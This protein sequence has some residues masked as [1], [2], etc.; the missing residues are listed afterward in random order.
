MWPPKF[1]KEWSKSFPEARSKKSLNQCVGKLIRVVKKRL[2]KVRVNSSLFMEKRI[3]FMSLI[4]E[5]FEEKKIYGNE[6]S[7]IFWDSQSFWE[8]FWAKSFP[9][10]LKL[11]QR[12]KSFF[13]R[14][15]IFFSGN[16]CSNIFFEI[17]FFQIKN[18]LHSNIKFSSR[19]RNQES[20][21]L[22]FI[23]SI[24]VLYKIQSLNFF[25]FQSTLKAFKNILISDEIFFRLILP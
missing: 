25:E 1:R 13:E 8:L 20:Q 17:S 16:F 10:S 6:I 2:T 5:F 24:D 22:P 9:K 19:I 18:F 12:S 23:K 7:S 21:S 14:K 11:N 3:F 15:K 4:N